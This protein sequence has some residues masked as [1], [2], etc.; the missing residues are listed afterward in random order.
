MQCLLYS[1]INRDVKLVVI[2]FGTPGV[3][4]GSSPDLRV[5]DH[6]RDVLPGRLTHTCGGGWLSQDSEF[7]RC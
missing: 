6:L 5:N 2:L 3:G 7:E 1:V 4:R